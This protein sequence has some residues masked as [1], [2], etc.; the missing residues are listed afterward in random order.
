QPGYQSCGSF[1]IGAASNYKSCS[2]T[3]RLAARLQALAPQRAE[4]A[5]PLCRCWGWWSTSSFQPLPL[6][7]LRDSHGNPLPG[8]PESLRVQVTLSGMIGRGSEQSQDPARLV[9]TFVRQ[10]G[11][12]LADD[13][14]C[15]DAAGR[16]ARAGTSIYE[17]N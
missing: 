11:G 6:D 5:E 9:L 13:T 8:Q 3:P 17:A 10:S 14:A 4:Q 15:Y 7:P 12:W 16:G 1:E 2:V